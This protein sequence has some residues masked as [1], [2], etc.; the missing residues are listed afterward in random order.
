MY[1][2]RTAKA[3]T[4]K[5]AI[6]KLEG[7]YHGSYDPLTVSAK[8][9]L[10]QAGNPEEPNPVIGHGINAG[11]VFVVPFNNLPALHLGASSRKPRNSS[12]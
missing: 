5:S 4:G 7:G 8:P 11:V 2:V 12:S 6:V 3:F 10:D 9:S 1:A